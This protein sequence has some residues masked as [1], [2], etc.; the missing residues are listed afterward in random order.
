MRTLREIMTT[1][2]NYVTPE[3]NVYEVARLMKEHNIGMVPVVENGVLKGILTDRDI[4]IRGIA[5]KNPNSSAVSEIMTQNPVYGTPD[6]SV[7][8]AA[9]I[10]ANAQIRRLPVVENNQ[11]VGVV[12]LGDIA[13]R[14]PFQ[15]EAGWALNQISQTHNPN[16]SSDLQG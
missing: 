1:D 15:D 11:L 14:E 7:H 12:S 13:V 5:E 16:V 9:Q 2:V 6:M 8:E 10:M 3:D 4:V